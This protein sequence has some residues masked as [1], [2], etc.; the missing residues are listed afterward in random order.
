M[1]HVN[2]PDTTVEYYGNNNGTQ[3][4]K[5]YAPQNYLDSKRNVLPEKS[6]YKCYSAK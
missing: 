5:G 1:G 2:R 4:D 6:Y 3:G